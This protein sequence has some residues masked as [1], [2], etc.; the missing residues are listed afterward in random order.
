MVICFRDGRL[1]IGDELL[2]INGH[3]LIG[4]TQSEAVELLVAASS[5]V[6][7]VIARDS[8]SHKYFISVE[9]KLIA[10]NPYWVA[11]GLLRIDDDFL[12]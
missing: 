4:L 2:W 1:K 3:H 7:L 12:F 8:V 10:V 6:Q 9:L 11:D 5:V